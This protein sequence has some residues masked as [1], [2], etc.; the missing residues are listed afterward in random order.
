MS[1]ITEWKDMM[2]GSFESIWHEIVSIV[3][4][5]LGAFTILLLGWLLSKIIVKIIKKALKVVKADKLD[6]K[7][8]GVNFFGDKKITFNIINIIAGFVKWGLFLVFLILAT[9]VLELTIISAEIS[10][11]LHY[12]PQLF[13]AL[14]LLL[15][16]L[17]IASFVKNTL[18][19]FFKELELSGGRIISN[20]VFLI[21]FV[22]IAVTALNQAGI[23]TEIITNNITLILG[24]LLL[25]L[26]LALGLG[27]KDV[28]DSL[29]KAYYTRRVFMLGQVIS[30]KDVKGEIVEVNEISITLKTENGTLI[31][32]VKE[33]VDN[34][35]EIQN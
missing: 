24:A 7:L 20:L 15:I 8:N 13:S 17:Y 27:A 1:K 34:Q 4:K 11:L 22:F 6:D 35:V 18:Y 33:I 10:N 31:V 19:S 3:P 9:Q 29:L 26:A 28:V 21:L 2:L 25:S 32:P 30:F 16:G 5:L 12:L 23:N 14:I